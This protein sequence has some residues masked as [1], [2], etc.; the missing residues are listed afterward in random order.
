MF[1]FI[2][3]EIMKYFS[4]VYFLPLKHIYF[5]FNKFIRLTVLRCKNG[6]HTR[7]PKLVPWVDTLRTYVTTFGNY[8]TNIE[9]NELANLSRINYLN[10]LL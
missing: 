3:D 4:K 8:E 7:V 5:D 6:G 10:C 9:I 2:E 1:N